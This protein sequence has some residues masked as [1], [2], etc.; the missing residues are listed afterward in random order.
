MPVTSS[1]SYI[2]RWPV[3]ETV[4]RALKEWADAQADARPD[5]AALGYFGSYARNE[6]A[7]GSDIDLIAIVEHSEASYLERARDWP[8]ERLPVPA[9]LL[10][11]TVAEWDRLQRR[12]GRFARVLTDEVVWLV[13]GPPGFGRDCS[14]KHRL[15]P[16]DSDHE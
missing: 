8:Y 6:A 9:D 2:K 12:G 10:V 1:T 3:A 4:L 13:G 11:Y 16:L 5:L 14:G 15:K 7:F